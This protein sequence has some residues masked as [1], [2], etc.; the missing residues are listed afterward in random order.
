M[1]ECVLVECAPRGA[2]LLHAMAAQ[3]QAPLAA[4]ATGRAT[5][6]ATQGVGAHECT[7]G[8]KVAVC[9]WACLRYA[10]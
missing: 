6:K 7:A 8:A 9:P 3:V 5:G 4:R 1:R 10:C 2:G